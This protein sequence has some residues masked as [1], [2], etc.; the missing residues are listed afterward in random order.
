MR[1]PPRAL[2]EVCEPATIPAASPGGARPNSSGHLQLYRRLGFTPIPL[3]SQ[4]KEPLVRWKEGDWEPDEPTLLALARRGVTNWAVRCGKELAVLDIDSHE[5][6]D[7]FLKTHPVLAG[8]PRV[9]TAR[10]G[11]IWFKP[12]RPLPS[13]RLEDVELK[14]LGS[15]IVAP[16]STHPS[17]RPY[18]FEVVPNGALPLVDLEE[19]LGL[20]QIDSYPREQGCKAAPSEFAL[21]YGKSAYAEVLCGLATKI[22]TKFDEELKRLLS[23]RCWKWHCPKCAPLLKRYWIDKLGGFS[24]RFILRLPTV[25][26]PTSFL[27]RLGKPDYV[28]IIANGEGW[29]FLLDGDIHQVWE[30]ARRAGYQLV[31][32]DVAGDPTSSEVGECLE[33]ALCREDEPLNTRRKITH[34][35][36]L[37][38][39]SR[40]SKQDNEP[41]ESKRQDDYNGGGDSMK[42]APDKERSKWASEVVMKPIHQVASEL[43]EEGW[44]ILWKS[45]VEA[46]AIKPDALDAQKGDIVKLIEGLGVKLKRVGSE[47]AGLCPFHNDHRASL[48]VNREKGLWHCFGCGKGGN[49]PQFVLEWEKNHEQGVIQY[50]TEKWRGR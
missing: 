49:I 41:N 28:H 50:I 14:C 7:A 27:R 8:C 6:F 15:Y 35:R 13:Q 32:G 5:K 19:L 3:K 45:E 46:V 29:L 48:S 2:I 39:K 37:L 40:E 17:G 1:Q 38:K 9:R 16:P 20:V 4:R 44:H 12:K 43:K 11:H 10:G 34:S 23:L 24:F 21:R 26:K 33:E 25:G 47:Y 18:T 30:E 22:L 42:K 31:A 36:G